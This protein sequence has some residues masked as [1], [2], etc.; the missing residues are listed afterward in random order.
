MCTLYNN[1]F[2]LEHMAVIHL[3]H[4]ID[5]QPVINKMTP[6][7]QQNLYAIAQD[8]AF[9]HVQ[10]LQDGCKVDDSGLLP[11]PYVC[12]QNMKSQAFLFAILRIADCWAYFVAYSGSIA[13]YL[14]EPD[15]GSPHARIQW[16]EMADRARKLWQI[17]HN[18]Y[19]YE[20]VITGRITQS[21]TGLT[22]KTPTAIHRCKTPESLNKKN[23]FLNDS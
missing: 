4:G 16:N 1:P 7:T 13:C 21:L 3:G 2:T 22:G 14:A 11:K 23:G 8:I 12:G 18:Q 9:G 6:L 10:W 19:G 20:Y 17:W 15:K 5:V